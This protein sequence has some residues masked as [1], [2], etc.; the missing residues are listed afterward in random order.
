[1]KISEGLRRRFNQ[2]HLSKKALKTQIMK[3]KLDIERFIEDRQNKMNEMQEE[4]FELHEAVWNEAYDELDLDPDGTYTY[5]RIK[6]EIENE[7][8]TTDSLTIE[9]L[10][11]FLDS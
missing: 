6:N 1:M 4:M 11:D 5:N 8:D 7:D 10:L 9:A 2:L 3:D